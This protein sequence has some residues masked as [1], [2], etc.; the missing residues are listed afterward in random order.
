[1]LGTMARNKRVKQMLD[2]RNEYMKNVDTLKVQVLP[3]NTKTGK[4]VYTVSLIPIADCQN[5]SLCARECYDI[6]NVCRF[7]AV[8]NL[9]AINS[10]IHKHDLK[11]FWRGVKA[12]IVKN[13]IPALRINVGGD[14]TYQDFIEIGS[15]AEDLKNVKFIFFTKNI[16]DLN[17]YADEYAFPDNVACMLSRWPGDSVD[18]KHHFPEAHVLFADGTTTAPEYGAVFCKGNCSR[19]ALGIDEGCFS[20]KKGESVIFEEH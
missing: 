15:M 1:M 18:N 9:R 2:L 19:C 4:S 3:G 6:N 20:L 10:A 16:D 11:A 14:L 12:Q 7:P 5:C 8:R 17:K 13:G